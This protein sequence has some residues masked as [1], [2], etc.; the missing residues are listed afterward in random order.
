LLA[1]CVG[2]GVLVGVCVGVGV[3]AVRESEQLL[4]AGLLSA[5]PGG[6]MTAQVPALLGLVNVPPAVGVTCT[7][8]VTVPPVGILKTLDPLP[9]VHVSVLLEM[10]QLMEPPTLVP[11][12]ADTKT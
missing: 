11:F 2:V 5:T 10:E 7:V 4:F 3:I 6:S 8:S 12:T 1:V 9:E